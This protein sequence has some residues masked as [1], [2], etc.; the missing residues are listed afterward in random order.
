MKISPQKT[1]QKSGNP[2]H[3]IRIKATAQKSSP[4]GHEP[5]QGEFSIEKIIEFN[6]HQLMA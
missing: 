1:Y 5:G 3:D 2:D 4:G 6:S